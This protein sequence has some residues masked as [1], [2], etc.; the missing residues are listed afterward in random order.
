MSKGFLFKESRERVTF[1]PFPYRERGLILLTLELLIWSYKKF[2]L[3]CG[4]L[5]LI[6]YVYYKQRGFSFPMDR[7]K[8]DQVT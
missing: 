6:V 1:Y 4:K 3:F 5:S 8:R 7:A 2:L